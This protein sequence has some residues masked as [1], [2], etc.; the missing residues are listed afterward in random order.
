MIHH[1]SI[2]ALHPLRVASVLAEILNGRAYKFLIPGSYTV[3]PFDKYGTAVAVFKQGDVWAPGMDA[4]PA[5]VI[6][7][8]PN[9]LVAIHAASSVPTTQHQIEQIGRREGWHVL[10][11]KQGDAPFSVVEFWLENR[12]LLEF[13]PPGFETEYLQSMQPE[14]IEQILGQPI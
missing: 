10:T 5:Q 6:Q 4:E 9:D 11:R 7:T 12:L 8:T 2:D 14:V 3:M 13:L 1:I